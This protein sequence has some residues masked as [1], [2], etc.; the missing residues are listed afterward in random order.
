MKPLWI[1]LLM[2]LPWQPA[3]ALSCSATLSAV[4]FGSI[5]VLS[6]SNP[7]D[8][9]SGTVTISC[10]RGLLESIGSV[11]ACL[12]LG[13][14][15]GGLTSDQSARQL[16]SGSNR[17]RFNLYSDP[18]LTMPWGSATVFT[19]QGPQRYVLSLPILQFN[20]SVSDTLYGSI[21]GSQ[22][23]VAVG[24]YSSSFSGSS[25]E[26]RYGAGNVPC[27]GLPSSSTTT[28]AV[29]A[30]VVPN[31][32]ISATTLDFGST[33][34]QFSS[35]LDV[36]SSIN[37]ICTRD[38]AYQIALDNGSNYSA[39]NRRMASGANRV[40]YD[41]YRDAARSQRWGSSLGSDTLSGIGTGSTT[42]TPVYGRVPVQSGLVIG[43][44]TD[45]IV[46][47]ISF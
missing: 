11:T 39:P 10:S 46:A 28:F 33:G 4:D 43:S 22:S 35:N 37:T 3:H 31:C 24:S 20:D 21:S 41:L 7:L 27:A 29:N 8:T 34:S 14:G 13:A 2:L 45:T 5:D 12:N 42:T 6:S 47:T 19:A 17:L 23:G 26:L 30:T 38:A 18:A 32:T 44:Y 36:G 40:N 16:A 15:S 9:S 1:V 25:A